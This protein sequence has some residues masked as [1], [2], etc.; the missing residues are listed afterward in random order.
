[1]SYLT[2]YELSVV[3]AVGMV[4]LVVLLTAAGR[5][6]GRHVAASL[7]AGAILVAVVTLVG[8]RPQDVEKISAKF[9]SRGAEI[10]VQMKAIQ[11]D[12]YAKAKTVRDLTER[13]GELSA[14]TAAQLWRLP[15]ASPNAERLRIRDELAALLKKATLTQAEITNLLAPITETITR[16]LASD[17]LN[18]VARLRQDSASRSKLVDQV[19]RSKPGTAATVLRPELEAIGAWIP[20]VEKRIAEVEEFRLRGRLPEAGK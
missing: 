13:V 18:S 14:Y 8:G 7:F 1:M 19:L 12:V 16:D 3:L 6:S 15:P 9:G 5:I 10:L 4:V 2:P 17:A 11:S 20:E